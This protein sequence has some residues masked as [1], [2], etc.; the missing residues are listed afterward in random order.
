MC[1]AR[2]RFNLDAVLVAVGPKPLQRGSRFRTADNDTQVRILACETPGL[3]NALIG[4]AKGDNP[5]KT[6]R[7]GD[8][9]LSAG[10]RSSA[11]HVTYTRHP[12]EASKCRGWQMLRG[13]AE[14]F[15]SKFHL[16]DPPSKRSAVAGGGPRIPRSSKTVHGAGT[17]PPLP[18]NPN[19]RWGRTASSLKQGRHG[20]DHR[21]YRRFEGPPRCCRASEW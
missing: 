12:D 19:S 2:R 14:V 8:V 18:S 15:P 17:P 11:L 7:C 20:E 21:W 9:P 4:P 16:P 13:R 1:A 6:V 5:Y 10:A 3:A